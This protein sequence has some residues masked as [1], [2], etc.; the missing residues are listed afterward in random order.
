MTATPN[1]Y[2]IYVYISFIFISL[3]QKVSQFLKTELHYMLVRLVRP[4]PTDRTKIQ[5]RN[6]NWNF[7]LTSA[8]QLLG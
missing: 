2:N 4:K 1:K 6:W 7:T 5:Q 3:A 8:S